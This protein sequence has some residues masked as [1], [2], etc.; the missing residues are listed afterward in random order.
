MQI[1]EI[2]TTIFHSLSIGFTLLL[3][4]KFVAGLRAKVLASATIAN[5][6]SRRSEAIV[7]SM[8]KATASETAIA[9]LNPETDI[10]VVAEQTVTNSLSD[11][12]EE[13]P[14]KPGSP[15]TPKWAWMGSIQGIPSTEN[16]PQA[17]TPTLKALPSSIMKK[18]VGKFQN[19]SIRELKRLASQAKIKGY[20][21]LSK[22]E[23]IAV[24][25]A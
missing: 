12:W 18:Q 8:I 22:T 24:L 16:L 5:C 13:Q 25:G 14:T 17:A 10:P 6:A 4:Y 1:Q 3:G 23:L 7:P 20:S 15:K 2:L 19:L 21:K 9:P 11:P